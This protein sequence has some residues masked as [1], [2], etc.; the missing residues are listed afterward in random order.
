[1]PACS[2]SEPVSGES[3]RIATRPPPRKRLRQHRHTAMAQTFHILSIDGGGIRGIIPALVLAEIEKRTG[4]PIAALFDLIAGTSTGGILGAGLTV[5]GANGSP[6]YSAAAM[7][8][9]YVKQ[10]PA[11]FPR[12]PWRTLAA[13]FQ[14]RYPAAGIESVLHEYFGDARLKDSVTELLVTSY[15]IRI[16]KPW[17]FR[18]GRARKSAEYDFAMW[19]VAR[20]TSAAPTYFPPA[21]LR[22]R[23]GEW[24]LIDGGT[25]ANN[26]AMCA[27]AEA[28]RMCAAKETASDGGQTADHDLAGDHGRAPGHGQVSQREVAPERDLLL[29]SLGTGRHVEAVRCRAGLIG[30]ARPILDVVFDG[31]SSAAE[32]QVQQLFPEQGRDRRYFRFQ[33]DIPPASG[34]MDDTSP[35]NLAR[36]E[37]QAAMLIASSEADLSRLCEILS[38][39]PVGRANGDRTPTGS[40][41]SRALV[42]NTEEYASGPIRSK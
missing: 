35:E 18:S 32:Y 13:P 11:I 9:L 38:A 19:Q 22:T 33:T 8:D 28:R 20:A 17:F 4:R 36:L 12:S 41:Q 31:V 25:F 7:C 1:L 40:C 3:Y 26:P 30:W 23:M 37:E 5:P 21:V 39:R 34:R 42:S 14:N 24:E 15:E 6:R 2:K 29:V 10:G 16:R 27:Y